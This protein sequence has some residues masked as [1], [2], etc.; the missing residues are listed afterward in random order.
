MADLFKVK[1]GSIG[2]RG[3]TIFDVFEGQRKI[4]LPELQQ[5]GLNIDHIAEGQAPAGFKSEFLPAAS[6]TDGFRKELEK[7]GL[8]PETVSSLAEDQFNEV[9]ESFKRQDEAL[10]RLTELGKPSDEELQLESD[11]DEL[12]EMIR[13]GVQKVEERSLGGAILKSAVAN[14]IQA[15]TQGNTRESL[16]ILRSIDTKTRL[17][18]AEQR[19]RQGEIEVE[20]IKLEREGM[21]EDRFFKMFNLQRDM[22]KDEQ[23]R[24]DR[25]NARQKSYLDNITSGFVGLTFD[26]LTPEQQ[27]TIAQQANQID[28]SGVLLA[29]I[30]NRMNIEK[31]ALELEELDKR[32]LI[33]ARGDS[34]PSDKDAIVQNL[35]GVGLKPGIMDTKFK[36]IKSNT[37]KILAKGVPTGVIDFIW[38][39]IKAGKDLETI[40]TDLT[41]LQEDAGSPDPRGAAFGSLD[42][43]MSALQEDG[44]EF[45]F[46]NL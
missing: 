25:L 36:L 29:S 28:P 12:N 7:N 3:E 34:I 23:E 31:N 38:K 1:T 41:K 5:R 13:Q 15:I 46:E 42:A 2:A 33:A 16:A 24:E 40:R 14:E 43:F 30:R 18:T 6:T 20:K 9:R 4:E 17:L 44:D 45:D 32:S 10:I 22:E 37:D 19:K 21:T 26:E 27:R 39:S 11:I 35:I 8:T